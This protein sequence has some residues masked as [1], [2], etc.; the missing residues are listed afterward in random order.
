MACDSKTELSTTN[1]GRSNLIA[2]SPLCGTPLHV[3]PHLGRYIRQY[4][5]KLIASQHQLDFVQKRLRSGPKNSV[6]GDLHQ[7][8]LNGENVPSEVPNILSSLSVELQPY[9]TFV[10]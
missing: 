4:I 8:L 7:S 1:K 6:C 10:I 2:D 9:P 3:F 5:F